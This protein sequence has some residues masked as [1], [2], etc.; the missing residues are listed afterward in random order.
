MFVKA[1][2]GVVERFPYTESD[3]LQDNP[4]TSFPQV[5]SDD[6]LATFNM[7]RVRELDQPSCDPKTE[8]PVKNDAP[9]LQGDEWVLGWH[10]RQ[11]TDEEIAK[12]L[13]DLADRARQLRDN[14]L[15]SCDYIVAI[16]YE[17]GEPVPQAWVDYRQALRDV[18]QQSGFPEDIVW[19][20]KP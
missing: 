10:I 6:F 20:E 4:N 7:Y 13:A 14:L 1:V 11:K 17:R 16:S 9:D 19:P 12:Y 15:S 2:S 8:E 3:L 18:P 5:R